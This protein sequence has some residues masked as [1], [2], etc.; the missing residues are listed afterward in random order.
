MDLFNTYDDLRSNLGIITPVEHEPASKPKPQRQ[1][2]SADIDWTLQVISQLGDKLA[3]QAD[4]VNKYAHDPVLWAKE[5]L[6]YDLWSKQQEIITSVHDHNQTAVYTCHSVGKSLCAAVTACWWIETRPPGEAFV[7]TTAP[8]DP[9]VAAILWREMNR[10]HSKGNLSGRMNL[11]DWYLG[12]ELV[13]IGRKPSDYNPTAFQGIHARYVLAILDEACGI[14]K[15]LWDAI[16]T[17]TANDESHTL[18]IGNPDDPHAEFASVCKPGSGWNVIQVGYEDTPNFTGEKVSEHVAA[19]LIA[20]RWVEDRKV[21]W[22]EDSALFSSKVKGEFPENSEDGV[23]PNSWAQ[24][25]RYLQLPPEGLRCAGLDVGGGGDRT[26][27]RERVGPKVGREK[28]W[29]ESDPNV[30]IG[31]IALTLEEWEIERV[32]IDVIG[33]G[34]ALAGRIREL[35]RAHNHVHSETTHGAEVIKFNASEKSTEPNRFFN[36]RAELHWMGREL[37]RL[38]QWDL[39]TVND[40]TIAELTEAKYVIV[41]SKG[42]IKVERK[43]EIK[44]RLSGMSPDAADSLLMAFWEGD[45]IEVN[46]P[47]TIQD[48]VSSATDTRGQD[49]LSHA[50]PKP[51]SNSTTSKKNVEATSQQE[52]ELLKDLMLR[53]PV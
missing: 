47:V 51:K 13:G 6:G 34:W 5:K 18:A 46:M 48:F 29:V 44:K 20:P 23:I 4:G 38:K 50:R 40:D 37:S 41:D 49:S 35:S 19:S 21:R 52:K 8:T 14:P 25:C 16:S 43:D 39:E 12:N 42:K 11:K 3:G 45:V 26:I 17:I 22:G 31:Q 33:I 53:R 28:I 24:Q 30:V 27:L 15:V 10:L 7:V 32:I 36:K 9:Q 1:E 2:S